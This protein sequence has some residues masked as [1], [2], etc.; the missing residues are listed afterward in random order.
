LNKEEILLADT[1]IDFEKLSS[2]RILERVFH[3]AAAKILDFFILFRD[4]DYSEGDIAK[5]T[6]L[7]AKTVSKE[8]DN[9]KNENYIKITRKS[10][11]SNMYKL[12]E[13]KYT[14]GLLVHY[15]NILDIAEEKLNSL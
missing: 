11:K 14:E 1:P 2:N 10:G 13:S 5:K 12:N 3:S 8:L 6:G 4:Y 15:K 7:S 9:L